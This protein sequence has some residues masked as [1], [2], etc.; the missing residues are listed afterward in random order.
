MKI[1]HL[2][3]GN[4][5]GCVQ[6][7][8]VVSWRRAGVGVGDGDGVAVGVAVD[9]GEGACV[10]V[11][12]GAGVPV[13]VGTTTVGGAVGDGG[14]TAVA[15][16]MDATTSTWAAELAEPAGVREANGSAALTELQPTIAIRRDN[17]EGITHLASFASIAALIL[18]T[19]HSDPAAK[20]WRNR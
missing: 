19:T 3:S 12:V 14:A 20:G 18:I 1:S 8:P 16:G 7:P 15:V 9:V 5:I 4:Q 11:A 6:Q 10:R 2:E 17:A 13:D